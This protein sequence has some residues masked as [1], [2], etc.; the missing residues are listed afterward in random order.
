MSNR[1]SEL[2][3]GDIAVGDSAQFTVAITADLVN[4]FADLSGDA[5]PLHVDEAY[6][7]TTQFGR[8]VAHGMIAGA[9][10]SRLVG[11]QLPGKYALYLSQ[12]LKFHNP[13]L[14]GDEIVIRGE[15]V[16]KTE[17]HHMIEISLTAENAASR[18]V[19]ASGTAM[20]KVLM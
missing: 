9:F 19:M 8:R 7:A 10:F 2:R 17:S 4:R 11:M 18:Q 12:T 20:V 1:S 15:V 14:I 5:N 16:H 13:I 3:Y 6:A